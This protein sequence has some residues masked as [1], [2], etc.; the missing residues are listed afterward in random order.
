MTSTNFDK[1]L[2][3]GGGMGMPIM[4]DGNSGWKSDQQPGSASALRR[5]PDEST[6]GATGGRK[7][8]KL[9]FCGNV[10]AS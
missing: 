4:E 2:P 8:S 7:P 6:G 5:R 9:C 10:A 1:I 3:E